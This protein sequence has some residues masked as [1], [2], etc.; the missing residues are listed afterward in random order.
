MSTALT[1]VGNARERVS[2]IQRAYDGEFNPE[3]WERFI[4]DLDFLGMI[5]S[6]IDMRRRFE[7]FKEL[8][9]VTA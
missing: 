1:I 5:L 6:A 9:K 3:E 7:Y 8:N 2:L 4:A